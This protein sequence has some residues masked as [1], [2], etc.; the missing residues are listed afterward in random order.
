MRHHR[1]LFTILILT[2]ACTSAKA[3][4]VKF[5]FG[6]EGGG[7]GTYIKT[8]PVLYPGIGYGGYGGANF[9]LR[10]GRV[11]GF[12][13]EAVYS[14]Q[15]GSYTLLT[16]QGYDSGL[17]AKLT[18]QYVHIPVSLHLWMG[19]SVIFEAGFQ[20]SILMGAEYT[21]TTGSNKGHTINPDNG[22]LEYYVSVLAGFKFNMGRVVY[23]NIRG[24]YGL[25]PAYVT[26]GNGAPAITASVGLG[27]RLYSY[28]KSAFK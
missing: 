2:L 13:A 15:T 27:F 26:M 6:I 3:Q 16:D 9:E 7:L 1:L 12:Y 4:F 17:T 18:Q 22:A 5:S 11:V 19:R 28:R 21:E 10:L 14:Y 24:T 25:S 20:Q 8:D 23:L